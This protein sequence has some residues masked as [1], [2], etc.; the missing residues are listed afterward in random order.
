MAPHSGVQRES[1]LTAVHLTEGEI[2]VWT[3]H[4]GSTSRRTRGEEERGLNVGGLQ[5]RVVSENFLLLG[6]RGEQF[7]N[8][9]YSH[10]CTSDAWTASTMA[11]LD[12]D[13]S[14]QVHIDKRSP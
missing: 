10:S 12:S 8:V 4:S 11:G 7:Q 6:A 2:I 5:E 13:T 1:A 9:H 3:K 14:E